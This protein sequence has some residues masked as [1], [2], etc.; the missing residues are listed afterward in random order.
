MLSYVIALSVPWLL[1]NL[2]CVIAYKTNAA[3][4]FNFEIKFNESLI[5]F[6]RQSKTTATN[7]YQADQ[8]KTTSKSDDQFWSDRTL[9]V[10][11]PRQQQRDVKE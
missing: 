5:S 6:R 1:W 7:D 8:L 9:R 10:L 2:K 4:N 3:P 11:P